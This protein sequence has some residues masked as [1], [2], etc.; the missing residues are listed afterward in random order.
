MGSSMLHDL[1]HGRRLELPW[2]GGAVVEMGE[3]AAVPTPA[4]RILA[5]ALSPY[6]QGSPGAP[7]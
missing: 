1:L 3:L 5:A 4:N 7:D 2:L 6:V